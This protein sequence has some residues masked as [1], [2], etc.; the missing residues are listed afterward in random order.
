M[1]CGKC[2]ACMHFCTIA[3]SALLNG[4]LSEILNGHRT[5]VKY[6][7]HNTYL[8]IPKKLSNK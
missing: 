5:G 1:K 6:A 4:A 8:S 7:L 3:V 2:H